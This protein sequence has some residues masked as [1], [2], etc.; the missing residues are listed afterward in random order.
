MIAKR[1]M[2]AK[3]RLLRE[4]KNFDDNDYKVEYQTSHI[5]LY[6]KQFK[7]IL[8]DY[9]FKPPKVYIN[10]ENIRNKLCKATKILQPRDCL[11]CNSILCSN[12]W[13]PTK[14]IYDIITEY[15][16]IYEQIKNR[17]YLKI[18]KFRNLRDWNL[19][20]VYEIILDFL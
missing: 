11:C 20:D 9:P 1:N 5:I 7:F 16:N 13:N 12:N 8:K 17:F 6:I 19:E 3:R 18:L 10:E 14:N 15:N 4:L 2:I